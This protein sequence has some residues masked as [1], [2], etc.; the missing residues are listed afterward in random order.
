MQHNI[1]SV[2]KDFDIEVTKK[3]INKEK[4]QRKNKN[5]LDVIQIYGNGI[6]IL[7]GCFLGYYI[8]SRYKTKPVF[9]LVLMGIG[10]ASGLY[11]IIKTIKQKKDA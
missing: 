8:D 4:Y 10:I 7:I 1:E 6:P 3:S 11:S 5:I 9:T 2:T